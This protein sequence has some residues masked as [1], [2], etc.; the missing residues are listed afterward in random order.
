MAPADLNFSPRGGPTDFAVLFNR[1]ATAKS[2]TSKAKVGTISI[3]QFMKLLAEVGLN[4]TSTDARHLLHRIDVDGNGRLNR[5]DFLA[6]VQYNDDELDGVAQKIRELFGAG[7]G[8][9]TDKVVKAVR[10]RFKRLDA[11]GDGILDIHEFSAMVQETQ[12]FLTEAELMR[13]RKVFDRDGDG[14]IGLEE[15]ESVVVA[16][17]DAH[18]RQC[19]RVCEAVQGMRDYIL[20]CQREVRKKG[21]KDNVDSESAWLD[22]ERKHTRGVGGTPFPGYL[23]VEDVAMCAE[24]LGFR[25]SQPETRMLIMRIAPDGD[26][27]VTED[28]FHYFAKDPKPRPI[29]ELISIM[30]KNRDAF[31]GELMDE[32]KQGKKLEK[33]I[34]RAVTAIGPDDVGLSTIAVSAAREAPRRPSPKAILAARPTDDPSP[35]SD[36]PEPEKPSSPLAH[37]KTPLLALS[38][39]LFARFA[40]R[41]SL[42]GCSR[43]STTGSATGSRP[44][45]SSWPSPSTWAPSTPAS[46]W[47]TPASS[48]SGFGASA[49]TAT[50]RSSSTLSKK[51]TRTVRRTRTFSR[52]ARRPDPSRA[53]T[54]ATTRTRTLTLSTS[55]STKRSPRRCRRRTP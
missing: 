53:P 52:S 15:F 23:D 49:P 3:G 24:R 50:P 48:S 37:P 14:M 29:G 32:S 42:P 51:R 40:R 5:E 47:L 16:E 1:H 26:G 41:S 30:G 4:V 22:L 45:A 46:S 34:N 11:D 2:M 27:R 17:Q 38:N 31:C 20:Q 54:A 25:L 9:R 12:I 13:L 18:K 33:Y 8:G 36:D 6:F 7:M 44:T 19:V 35:R 21:N 55:T 39:S 10:Q 43:S 28:D